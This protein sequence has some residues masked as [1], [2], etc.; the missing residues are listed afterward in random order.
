MKKIMYIKEKA[1]IP[2]HTKYNGY[3][4]EN[5]KLF[6]VNDFIAELT[7]HIP[8]KHKH[9]G[10]TLDCTALRVLFQQNKGEVRQRRK[11]CQVW[12]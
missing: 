12:V 7:M 4:K 8:P 10:N 3:W 5:I 11:P 9:L 6:K 2:Y 1:N